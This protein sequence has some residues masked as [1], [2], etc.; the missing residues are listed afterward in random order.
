M[1][2]ITFKGMTILGSIVALLILVLGL[3]LSWL[4]NCGFVYLISLC[5]GI[6]F[7]WLHATG[8]W[9]LLMMF[10]GI[11]NSGRRD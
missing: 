7:S 1:K 4:I 5:F 8:L 3:A 10:S 6:E 2:K 9:L 11:I